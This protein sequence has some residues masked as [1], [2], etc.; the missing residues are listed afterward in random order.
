MVLL[1]KL[2][3]IIVRCNLDKVYIIIGGLG[4]FGLELV[5]WLVEKGVRKLVFIF[6]FGIRI[7]Y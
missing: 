7:G 3:I 4:G 6:R 1:I 2:V 5:S